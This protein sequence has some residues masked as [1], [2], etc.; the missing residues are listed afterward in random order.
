[1][2][3]KH[4]SIMSPT[5]VHYIFLGM[6]ILAMPFYYCQFGLYPIDD[7]C[8]YTFGTM[9]FMHIGNAQ[10]ISH[11]PCLHFQHTGCWAFPKVSQLIC[12]FGIQL[13]HHHYERLPTI[14]TAFYSRSFWICMQRQSS[15][16]SWLAFYYHTFMYDI[17]LQGLLLSELTQSSYGSYIHVG[18]SHMPNKLS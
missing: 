17:C 14:Q 16:I 15:G 12:Q 5:S 13:G 3:W 4:S 11:A 10:P 8:F 6:A 18:A 9:I 7:W 2:P 1:M